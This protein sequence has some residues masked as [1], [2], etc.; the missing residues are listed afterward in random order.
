[1][2]QSIIVSLSSLLLI[3]FMVKQQPLVSRIDTCKIIISET[4]IAFTALTFV[5]YD[6]ADEM[7][8]TYHE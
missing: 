2:I 6:F 7:K 4:V 3:L 8:M 1:M 5:I